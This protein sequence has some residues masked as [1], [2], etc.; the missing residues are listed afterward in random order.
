MASMDSTS[1]ATP[2]WC[3]GRPAIRCWS[4]PPG[5]ARWPSST[6]TF[7]AN[8]LVRGFEGS[9][10]LP[11][12]GPFSQPSAENQM[13]AVDEVAEAA[14]RA[15]IEASPLLRLTSPEA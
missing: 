3:K 13:V 4:S 12:E 11:V 14:I 10:A 2:P 7:D 5:S 8:G 15:A 9:I 6:S 1:A